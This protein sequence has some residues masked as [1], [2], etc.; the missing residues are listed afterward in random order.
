MYLFV[1]MYMSACACVSVD[2]RMFSLCAYVCV[3]S[4][5]CI[6]MCPYGCLRICVY[7]CMYTLRNGAA[8][9]SQN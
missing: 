4:C 2:V 6:C 5:V 7:V 3:F 1:R 8:F 9:F